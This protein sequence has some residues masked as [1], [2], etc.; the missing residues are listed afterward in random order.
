M[1]LYSLFRCRA[2]CALMP[3]HTADVGTQNAPA[4]VLV[5]DSFQRDVSRPTRNPTKSCSGLAKR[6]VAVYSRREY[7]L[8]VDLC[9]ARKAIACIIITAGSVLGPDVNGCKFMHASK[10]LVCKFLL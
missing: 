8:R 2:G 10:N 7:L 6:V 1:L 9:A 4:C 5:E 3:I